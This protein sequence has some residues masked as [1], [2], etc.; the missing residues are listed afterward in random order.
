MGFSGNMVGKWTNEP[1]S[2]VDEV[3]NHFWVLTATRSQ[4]IYNCL[5]ERRNMNRPSTQS[6]VRN[7]LF[8]NFRRNFGEYLVIH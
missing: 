2:G 6:I 8:I 1:R 4:S 3:V 7:E 5:V